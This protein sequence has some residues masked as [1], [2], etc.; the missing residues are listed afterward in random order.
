MNLPRPTVRL[1][2]TAL[3]A[4]PDYGFQLRDDSETVGSLTQL[5]DS[6]ESGT[7]SFRPMRTFRASRWRARP[8]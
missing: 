6:M 8:D 4:G 7:A 1:R 5:Y 3:Y 2:L